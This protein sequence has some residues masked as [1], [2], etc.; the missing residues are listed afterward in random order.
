MPDSKKFAPA[1]ARLLDA[2]EALNLATDKLN[3]TLHTFEEQLIQANVGIEVWLEDTTHRLSAIQ[4]AETDTEPPARTFVELG[5][6]R[7]RDGWHLVARDW[8]ATL[9]HDGDEVAHRLRRD[10]YALTHASRAERM[11]ALPL[12]PALFDALSA[13]AIQHKQAIDDAENLIVC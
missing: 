10:P 5:F 6:A 12:M 4:H 2:A 3:K 8:E 9:D 7:L 1:L 11:A 13:A